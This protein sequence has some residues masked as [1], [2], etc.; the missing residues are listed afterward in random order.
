MNPLNLLRS[1]RRDR[2]PAERVTSVFGELTR[3]RAADAL[4]IPVVGQAYVDEAR[5]AV[6]FAVR[7]CPHLRDIVIVSDLPAAAFGDLP[8]PARVETVDV[9]ADV[10]RQHAYRQ[11]FKSRLVKLVA[12][13]KGRGD[14]VLMTDSDL[15]LL[16][17]PVFP[18]LERAV[19]G[20]FRSGNMRTKLRRGKRYIRP[21]LLLRSVR[22]HLKHH[23]NGGF[24]AAS[25]DTWADLSPRWYE[26]FVSL[27]RSV[28][29]DQQPTDQI[30]LCLALDALGVASIDLGTEVNWPV[31]K[32]I[33]G[34]AAPIPPDVI[35]AHG[36]FPISE[37]E[38]YL[39]DPLASLSFQGQEVTRKVRYLADAERDAGSGRVE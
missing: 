5:L 26:E 3:Y 14:Y 25:R 4:V 17:E 34:R 37:W 36:G 13:A 12:P 23:L 38:K 8:A 29:D 22:M 20:A 35:G 18:L 28:P 32:I 24:I 21:W 27:W 7:S 33:G 2:I 10:P 11:I 30:A 16:R 31:S 9:E 19:C 1:A 6:R 39:A 15:V